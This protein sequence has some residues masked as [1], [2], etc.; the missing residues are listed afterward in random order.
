MR[1]MVSLLA[2]VSF[3]SGVSYGK[4]ASKF[5]LDKPHVP[6]ELIVKFKNNQNS[7]L[8]LKES[9]FNSFS[10]R[11]FS[12]G[13]AVV[14]NFNSQ[15]SANLF[16]T[17]QLEQV[18]LNLAERKDVEY[19]EANSI[20]SINKFPNDSRFTELYGLHN[21]GL[22]GGLQGADI[23]APAAWDKSVGSKKVIVGVIDTGI[24]ASHPDLA[25]NIWKN[26]GEVGTD[27]S[28]KDK[29]TNGVDDDNNGYIDDFRGWD[30][31]NNDN[32]PFDDN[33]HG[34]HT[35]GTIGARGND[36]N[37]VVGVNWKVSLV[38]LKFLTGTGSG[39]LENA[40]KAIEYGTKMGVTLT[41]NSWGGGGYSQTMF[42]AIDGAR[43]AGIL[44]VAA[45]GNDSSDNDRRATYPAGYKLD[46]IISVA[47]TDSQDKLASF[48]NYGSTT[49]HLGAPGVQIL[50]TVPGNGYKKFDGTSMACPHVA[51]A[52]A[53]LKAMYPKE[54]WQKIKS[55]LILNTDSVS[56]L[57]GKTWSGGRLNLEKA[58][59]LDNTPPSSVGEM[60]VLAKDVSSV[61][62]QM[63]PAFDD[64][65]G[66]SLGYAANYEVRM[67]TKP[68]LT[69]EDWNQAQIPV[70]TLKNSEELQNSAERKIELTISQLPLNSK[71]FVSVKAQD[72]VGQTGEMSTPQEISTKPISVLG[73]NDANSMKNVKTA[74]KWGIETL[75]ERTFFS[76][77]PKKM[78]DNNSFNN[79]V[80]ENISVLKD[81]VQASHIKWDVMYN[82]ESKYD[83]GIVS[84]SQDNGL[85]FEELLS[86]T[87]DSTTWKTELVSLER[88]LKPETKKI[89][90]KFS[91][92]SD[93]SMAKE[94]MFI[95]NIESLGIK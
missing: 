65:D 55:R 30:F 93:G 84:L 58:S 87:G 59:E 48:S 12:A 40:V 45:A 90:L 78:Y 14:L 49:V 4:P 89:M 3:I 63:Q 8:S 42:N 56:A 28:G 23:R 9:E 51:G 54:T 34:T 91:V 24:D 83:F 72:N 20:L 70:F 94:G 44:F 50:S 57:S 60:S 1:P 86:Y 88:K 69:Q 64:A 95:D 82:L 76:D 5:N 81:G 66:T 31:A 22:L 27:S 6:G 2:A 36:K 13:G 41:S 47:A 38:G 32:N 53:L 62:L 77:S 67:A 92:K 33:E 16:S 39:S 11:N 21:T 80:T 10:V 61:T 25:P 46:N 73:S 85:T 68:I 71:F 19:V 18:A 7:V 29:S 74:G 79:L 75:N 15:N 26:K 43:K 37:G 52:A 35:A 17:E